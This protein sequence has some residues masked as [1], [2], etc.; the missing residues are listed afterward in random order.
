MHSVDL[1]C[2][3][4]IMLCMLLLNGQETIEELQLPA[5]LCY[6]ALEGGVFSSAVELCRKFND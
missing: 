5:I 1:T 3:P 6:F 4:C 2:L